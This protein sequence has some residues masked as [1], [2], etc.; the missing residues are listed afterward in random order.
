[1]ISNDIHIKDALKVLNEGIVELI[2]A[3]FGGCK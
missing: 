1:M 3:F 2:L